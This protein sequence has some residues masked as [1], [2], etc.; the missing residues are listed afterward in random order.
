MSAA[1]KAEFR[2]LFTTRMWW[3]LLLIMVAYLGF[4]GLLMSSL[5]VFI[6][7]DLGVGVSESRQMAILLYSFASPLGYVFPLLIGSLLFTSEYRHKTITA[8]LLVAPNRTVLL[9]SKLIV[10]MILGF[11]YGVVALAASVGSAAPILELAGSGAYLTDTEVLKLGAGTVW[12]FVLWAM[13]GVAFG[14]LIVNQIA[15]IIV[16]IAMTQFIEPIL[17]IGLM[18]SEIGQKIGQFLPAA[19]GSAIVGENA[20]AMGMEGAAEGLS[21]FEGSLVLLAYIA[22]FAVLARLITLRRDIG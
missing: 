9:A 17:G 14:G 12:V 7:D 8:S 4:M 19:A 1:I 3:I 6:D 20:M 13:M 5:F 10:G 21:R 15:A 11:V 2:K 22:V 16:L 18:F